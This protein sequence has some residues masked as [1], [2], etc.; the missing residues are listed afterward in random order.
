MLECCLACSKHC[1]KVDR[2][3]QAA[4]ASASVSIFGASPSLEP[5]CDRAVYNRLQPRISSLNTLHKPLPSS[6][7][8]A[9]PGS[10]TWSWMFQ[11]FSCQFT[12]C[13]GAC[14]SGVSSAKSSS[15]NS[16]AHEMT[17]TVGGS[18]LH[19]VNFGNPLPSTYMSAEMDSATTRA[20]GG[21]VAVGC[22]LYPISSFK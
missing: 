21:M 16:V 15:G 9:W 1:F 4:V 22:P 8:R 11:R 19:P 7:V 2:N 14:L 6:Q 13:F 10:W 17:H 12:F 3:D 18:L 20:T 5:G